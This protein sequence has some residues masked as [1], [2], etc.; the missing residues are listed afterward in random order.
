MDRSRSAHGL[1]LIEVDD[2]SH[3]PLSSPGDAS[4]KMHRKMLTPTM[5]FR[6][7]EDYRRTMNETALHFIEKLH[8]LGNKQVDIYPMIRMCTFGIVFGE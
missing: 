2:S 8:Q 4:W 6:I 5:H 3:F 7:L 1:K